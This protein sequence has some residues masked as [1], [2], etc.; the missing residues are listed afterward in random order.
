MDGIH[1]P[2]TQGLLLTIDGPDVQAIEY[3]AKR[4]E[5]VSRLQLKGPLWTFFYLNK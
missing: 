2:W 4:F 1:G 5:S 3:R